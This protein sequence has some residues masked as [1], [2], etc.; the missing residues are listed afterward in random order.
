MNE[1]YV[2]KIRKLDGSV[3]Y[4]RT[5]NSSLAEGDVIKYI[6]TVKKTSYHVGIV[7]DDCAKNESS[8]FAKTSMPLANIA[9]LEDFEEIRSCPYHLSFTPVN[10][11]DMDR[12]FRERY[13]VNI[14]ETVSI[15][16]DFG[17]KENAD[18]LK[19]YRIFSDSE[20][21]AFIFSKAARRCIAFVRNEDYEDGIEEIHFRLDAENNAVDIVSNKSDRLTD[22]VFA[23][24]TFALTVD[25]KGSFAAI[26]SE[27]Y[28]LLKDGADDD[29]D[30]DTADTD[31]FEPILKIFSSRQVS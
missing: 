12:D 2:Y 24:L 13:F 31:D 25:F 15:E 8:F 7:E 14:P 17:L 10:I 5:R 26:N 16:V 22:T 11:A 4:I 18:M 23:A 6:T 3:K 1:F 21:L 9:K 30:N 29:C 20:V 28:G 27:L 19:G